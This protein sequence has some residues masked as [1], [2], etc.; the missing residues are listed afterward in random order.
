MGCF[1]CKNR[2]KLLRFHENIYQDIILIRFCEELMKVT[3]IPSKS[4]GSHIRPQRQEIQIEYKI[5]LRIWIRIQIQG[6]NRMR[7]RIRIQA[8]L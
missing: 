2:P 8:S 5:S 4:F 6:V 7:I 1:W 3:N